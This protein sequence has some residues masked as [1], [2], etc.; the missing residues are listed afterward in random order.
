MGIKRMCIQAV[1]GNF[2]HTCCAR[3]AISPVS[4]VAPFPSAVFLA[5]IEVTGGELT[6]GGESGEWLHPGTSAKDIPR[7][8]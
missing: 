2:V 8:R 3:T 5:Q 1:E 4:T 6:E 7:E